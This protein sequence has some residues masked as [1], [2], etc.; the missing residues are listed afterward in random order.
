MTLTFDWFSVTI[1]LPF[2]K[3][4]VVVCVWVCVR[5]SYPP[6]PTCYFF[7]LL[8]GQT[9]WGQNCHGDALS[10]AIDPTG[11]LAWYN[12]WF[13]ITQIHTYWHLHVGLHEQALSNKCTHTHKCINAYIQMSKCICTHIQ[14]VIVLPLSDISANGL[15]PFHRQGI[16]SRMLAV[17]KLIPMIWV[18]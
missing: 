7:Q 4:E 13:S 3:D 5:F 1:A 10:L 17:R 11:V 8:G 16:V 9:D 2:C 15:F 18:R 14:W 12:L 6:F